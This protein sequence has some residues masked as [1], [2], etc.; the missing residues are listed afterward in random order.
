MTLFLMIKS[1][2]N[3]NEVYH[4]QERI[5]QDS[6]PLSF[7]WTKIKQIQMTENY[8]LT[9]L[10]FGYLHRLLWEGTLF[11]KRLTLNQTNRI[12]FFVDDVCKVDF[13]V[14]LFLFSSIANSPKCL[15]HGYPCLE[16]P[17][18]PDPHISMCCSE[19]TCQRSTNTQFACGGNAPSKVL[20]PS[21]YFDAIS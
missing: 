21:L 12:N 14:S 8:L 11:R 18:L 16:S 13:S 19:T 7:N 2:R 5:V 10:I 3:H 17:H 15:S 9:V 4:F 6:F 1:D 20:I